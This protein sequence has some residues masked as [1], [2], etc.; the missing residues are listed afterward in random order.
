MVG[1]HH[2]LY[3]HGFGWTLVIGDGQG[4]LACCGSRGCKESD[5]NER[6]N[7]TELSIPHMETLPCGS[8]STESASNAWDQGLIP[9]LRRSPGE[10]NG[11]PLQY[12]CLDN[13]M[14]RGTWLSHFHFHY[15]SDIFINI[16]HM[17]PRSVWH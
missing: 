13:S 16:H 8:D 3:G 15:T 9:G 11:N 12:L 17:K 5:I 7:W 14:D 4:G 6:L 10:G 1:W 2:R